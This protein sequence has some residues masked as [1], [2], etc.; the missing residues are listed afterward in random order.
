M[1]YFARWLTCTCNLSLNK[2]EKIFENNFHKASEQ[3][4]AKS[5][6]NLLTFTAMGAPA[7]FEFFGEKI[8]RK[9]YVSISEIID[10]VFIHQSIT[11][12]YE[13]RVRLTE[14]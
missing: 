3:E 6:I 10:A 8:P 11:G 1:L 14:V 12:L 13:T 7:D 2:I 5:F 4:I 9:R